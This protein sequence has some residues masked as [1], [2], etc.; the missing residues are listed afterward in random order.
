MNEISIQTSFGNMNVYKSGDGPQS[1]V[2]LHGGG[3]D[4]AMLS[5]GN[6]IPLFD[7]RYTV[8]AID[9]L[10]Y[11][12]SDKPIDLQGATF[13]KTH[14]ESVKEIADALQIKDFIL[15]G[16]SMGG[17]ISIAF[18][19]KYPTYVK[20]LLPVAPWGIS[21]KLPMHTLSYYYMNKTD[22]TLSMFKWVAKSKRM[23]KW[24]ITYSLFGD[25]G[26][27]T[28]R[29]I[30]EVMQT[31]QAPFVGESMLQFQRS[32]ITKT[33]AIPYFGHELESLQMP[34]I[35]VVGDKDPLVPYKDAIA[36]AKRAP[37]GSFYIMKGCK[38]WAIKERP[39][40]FVELIHNAML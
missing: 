13:Y 10:G 36:A 34:V 37:Y 28:S 31:C 18:T 19:L 27:V 22:L 2:L 21:K 4:Y 12:K 26:K 38:H 24:F 3:C 25:K 29:L 14:I 5:W 15:A 7:E 39:Y 6:V 1:V 20:A 23:A 40:E 30:D 32:S 11:G 9:F 8:Y 16:L 33:S 17:A 35:F